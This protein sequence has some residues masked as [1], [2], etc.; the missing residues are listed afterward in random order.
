MKLPIRFQQTLRSLKRALWALPF[1]MMVL[2]FQNCMQGF[3]LKQGSFS[4]DEASLDTP[5]DSSAVSDAEFFAYPYASEP[6]FM[7]DVRVTGTSPIDTTMTKLTLEGVIVDVDRPE[8]PVGYEMRWYGSS[9]AEVCS[10]H[11]DVT[12]SDNRV[13]SYE[14]AANNWGDKLTGRL[15]AQS[16]RQG[17]LILVRE[18]EIT[19][20]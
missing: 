15:Y 8:A 17:R 18:F 2:S 5:S 11:S 16:S 13:F 1:A 3:Q 12:S 20:L 19:G 4:S 6:E 14:C 7:G 10:V 9:G